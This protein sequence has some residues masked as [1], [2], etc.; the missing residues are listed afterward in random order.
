MGV[1]V[2]GEERV[3]V[4][5]VGVE[6]WADDEVVSV[7]GGGGGGGADVGDAVSGAGD[8]GSAVVAG[9]GEEEEE[10]GDA[11]EV[12]SP[13]AAAAGFSADAGEKEAR[14]GVVA[15]AAD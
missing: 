13:L 2:G 3:K 6:G 7:L 8:G 11:G 1:G 5:Q 10:G 12:A 9:R 15:C 4:V 14:S